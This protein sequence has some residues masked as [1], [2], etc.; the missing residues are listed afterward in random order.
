MA[1]DARVVKVFIASPRDTVGDRDAVERALH[2]WNVNRARREKIVLLPWRWERHAVP[3][4]GAS[5]QSI[6]DSQALDECDVLIA[7]F[8]AYLGTE[9][10]GAVSGTAH[11]ILRAHE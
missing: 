8:N 3:E 6:I 9:T 5:V 4:L 11:E 2:D 1:F 10:D 7:L